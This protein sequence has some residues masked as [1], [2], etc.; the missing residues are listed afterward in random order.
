MHAVVVRHLGADV[1]DLVEVADPLLG[2]H[3]VMVE[4][5]AAPVNYVDLLTMAGQYQ[6]TPELPYTPGK[7]PAG[8]VRA[9]GSAVTGVSVGDRVLAMAEHGGYADR[10]VADR[11]QVYRI[12]PSLSFVDAASMSLAFDTAWMALRERARLASGDNVLVLGASG[13]VGAAAVQLA[14]AMGAGRVLAGVSSPA[15]ARETETAHQVIDLSAPDL[16]DNLRARVRSATDGAGADVVI[17]PVGGDVF[18]AALRAVAWRGRVVVVGFAS[19]RIPIV[20]VNYL[21]LKNIELSG[22][23]ISDYRERKPELLEQCYREIFRYYEQGM[24][25]PLA[26]RP[27]PLSRWGSALR[28][29]RSRATRERVVLVPDE[30]GERS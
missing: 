17:D 25:R 9:V 30:V 19:G 7:G 23:Q 28:A 16:R 6:F 2:V 8:V 11:R 3:D 10:V 29:V 24:V 13:A 18:D 5:H 4:V 21:M 12:P 27:Y 15:R 14:A 26:S 20:R 1:G 22:L